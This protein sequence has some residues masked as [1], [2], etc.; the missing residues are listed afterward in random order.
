MSNE[1]E[2]LRQ[3]LS[4]FGLDQT[5][6]TL[7]TELQSKKHLP[8]TEETPLFFDNTDEERPLLPLSLSQPVLSEMEPSGLDPEPSPAND[9]MTLSSFPVSSIRTHHQFGELDSSNVFSTRRGLQDSA[10]DD[11][12]TPLSFSGQSF[13]SNASTVFVNPATELSPANSPFAMQNTE[14]FSTEIQSNDF[15]ENSVHQGAVMRVNSLNEVQGNM[16]SAFSLQ[17]SVL[18]IDEEEETGCKMNRELLMES[19]ESLPMSQGCSA[20]PEHSTGV[21]Q[22]MLLNEENF[23]FPPTPA[24]SET[25]SGTALRQLSGFSSRTLSDLHSCESTEKQCSKSKPINASNSSQAPDLSTGSPFSSS[26]ENPPKDDSGELMTDNK[27]RYDNMKRTSLILSHNAL[28]WASTPNALTFPI[29]QEQPNAALPSSKDP[30]EKTFGFPLYPYSQD[31]ID[32]TYD[33]IDLRIYHRKN[34]TGFERSKDLY[35]DRGDV[36][37]GRYQ[38]LKQVGSAV[39]SKAIQALDLKENKQVCLKMVKN[40]KD[41]FDQSLDEI[42]LLRFLNG[43][44]PEDKE[45]VV[46]LLDFFYYREHLFLVFELLKQNLYELQRQSLKSCRVS[47]SEHYFFTMKNIQIIA[48]Q[49]IRTLTYLHSHNIIH[50]DLKPENILIK[51]LASCTVKVID[52]GSSCFVSDE[53]GTYVQSRAYRAPEV[54]LGVDYDQ[55]VDLWSLGC[56]IVELYSGQVLFQTSCLAELMLKIESARGSVPDWMIRE[57]KYSHQYYTPSGRILKQSN[58]TNQVSE[59]ETEHDSGTLWGKRT[60]PNDL[61][62]H[63]FV[64]KLLTI[65]PRERPTADQME[66]HP[67]LRLECLD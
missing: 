43:M 46:R 6:A 37:A 17:S 57:G 59:S 42:K 44:D 32:E 21:G 66:Q 38:V 48:R 24:G 7:E 45:G 63:D 40:V 1:L 53:L 50:S 26:S 14:E 16:D 13:T 10:E 58:N 12:C 15:M 62:F 27:R 29:I 28:Q 60:P 55:K 2:H 51:D 22:Q 9:D 33:M 8:F 39:F 54:V 41:Y 30:T 20:D 35:V 4:R 25:G 11:P 5:L 19:A 49:L 61:R 65:D 36:I 56:I 52:L 3:E 67:W 47:T 23:S 64:S 34:K 18:P 31:Y